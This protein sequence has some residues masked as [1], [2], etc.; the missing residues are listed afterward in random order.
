MGSTTLGATLS[1]TRQHNQRRK[2]NI[3]NI[4]TRYH[5]SLW[6]GTQWMTSNIPLAHREQ[7]D[8]SMKVR[9]QAWRQP[10]SLPLQSNAS[11]YSSTECCF[12]PC[13]L[14]K[15]LFSQA[16][17]LQQKLTTTALPCCVKIAKTITTY[18]ILNQTPRVF[19]QWRSR[20]WLN[21]YC[22]HG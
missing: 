8:E 12:E 5:R 17:N 21:Q 16:F 1:L 22:Y 10:S 11:N 9:R 3:K 19:L 2:S 20:Y 15:H 14:K 13:G 7:T 4:Y 6:E 18:C